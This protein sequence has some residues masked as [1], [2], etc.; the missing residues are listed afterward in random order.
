MKNNPKLPN[1]WN[2]DLAYLFGLLLGDGSLPKAK[3]KRQNGEYQNRYIIHFFSSSKRF[4]EDIYIPLFKKVFGLMPNIEIR[5]RKDRNVIYNARI[6]SIIIYNF[7]KKLG[8]T[9][10]R[11]ARTAKVPSMPVKYKVCVLAGLLDTDGGKKGNG[12]GLST[13]SK[14]LALFCIKIFKK[15]D[16]PYHSTPWCYNNHIY[17]QI[18]MGKKNMYKILE[19]IPMKNK[20]KITYLKSYAPVA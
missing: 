9:T 17:H 7:L 16:L 5:K 4:S 3:S 19:Q 8:F 10:G 14:N 11:K 2:K 15:L 20:E 1:G 13:A 18:Y 6:E 12:F